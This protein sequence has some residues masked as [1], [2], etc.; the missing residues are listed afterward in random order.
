VGGSGGCSWPAGTGRW[1][2]R[3]PTGWSPVGPL[4]AT[5][6]RGLSLDLPPLNRGGARPHLHPP[7]PRRGSRRRGPLRVEWPRGPWPP[8]GGGGRVSGAGRWPR[9]SFLGLPISPAGE[10]PRKGVPS[11]T[12]RRPWEGPGAPLAPQGGRAGREGGKP[13][14]ARGPGKAPPPG[15]AFAPPGAL[16]GEGGGRCGVE[17]PLPPPRGAEVYLEGEKASRPGGRKRGGPPWVYVGE[18]RPHPD[19]WRPGASPLAGPPRPYPLEVR[20]LAGGSGR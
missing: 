15:E 1:C 2:P 11:C 20:G 13:P 12:S 16:L 4:G 17:A 5:G 14:G 18:A 3:G 6:R 19:P 9:R 8:G 10:G 7:F